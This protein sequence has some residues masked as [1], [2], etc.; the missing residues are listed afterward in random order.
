MLILGVLPALACVWIRFYVKE[1]EVWAEN[2]KIQND[3]HVQIKLPLLAIFRAQ[4]SLEHDHGLRVDGSQ[5]LCLLL[6]LG[7]VLDLS[8]ERIGLDA[9]N[10]GDTWFLGQYPGVFRVQLLG[11]GVGTGWPPLGAVSFRARSGS[12]LCRCI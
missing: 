11:P 9:Q 4:I 12:S 3:T 1:P 6:D 5:F 8:A 10:G 7:A 2:K